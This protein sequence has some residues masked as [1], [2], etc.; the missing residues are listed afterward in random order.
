MRPMPVTVTW[1]DLALRLALTVVAGALIGLNR[2]EHGRPA[3]LRTTLLVC[4]AASVAMIQ[5]NSAAADER[6][7]SGLPSSRS[8]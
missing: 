1:D 2:E 5:A 7:A 6:Q 8:I 4:L 3:G